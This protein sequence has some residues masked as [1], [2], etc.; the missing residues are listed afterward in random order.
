MQSRVDLAVSGTSTRS[1]I[2]GRFTRPGGSFSSA[3][4]GE[5]ALKA[6]SLRPGHRSWSC[7]ERFPT[8]L[9]SR[10]QGA[11]AEAMRSASQDRTALQS[12]GR[13]C[14][15]RNSSSM[16][17]D[18]GPACRSNFSIPKPPSPSPLAP[19]P[20]LGSADSRRVVGAERAVRRPAA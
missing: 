6:W 11:G 15:G 2:T 16:A 19:G 1:S 4:Q 8:R 17:A 18:G 14:R 13:Q 10:G 3:L 12:L 7:P 9:K 5:R 20:T